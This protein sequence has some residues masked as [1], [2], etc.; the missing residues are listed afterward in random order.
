MDTIIII[1]ICLFSQFYFAE[2]VSNF[3]FNLNFVAY[4][5]LTWAGK[6]KV[7]TN[8]KIKCYKFYLV[9]GPSVGRCLAAGS[10]RGVSEDKSTIGHLIHKYQF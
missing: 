5:Y 2:F 3:V 9:A 6:V 1:T 7:A 4:L 8:K 10:R